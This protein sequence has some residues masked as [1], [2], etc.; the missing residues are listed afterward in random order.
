MILNSLL[1]DAGLFPYVDGNNLL[2][3]KDQLALEI[4]RPLSEIRKLDVFFHGVQAEVY[5]KLLDGENVVR[6][7]PGKLDSVLSDILA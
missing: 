4:R 5:W 1:S 7:G 3:E 6:G 2:S